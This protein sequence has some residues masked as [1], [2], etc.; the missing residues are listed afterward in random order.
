M[1]DN[2]DEIPLSDRFDRPNQRRQNR[3]EV[4]E[5]EYGQ[6]KE[7]Y[8]DNDELDDFRETEDYQKKLA[9]LDWILNDNLPFM[10][11][12]NEF[13]KIHKDNKSLFNELLM[14]QS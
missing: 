3:E 6:N 12:F 2:V 4:T 14:I 10:E 9:N 8:S 11:H 7:A 5:F 1:C 13:I